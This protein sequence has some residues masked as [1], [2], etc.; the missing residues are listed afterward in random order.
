MSPADSAHG[1]GLGSLHIDAASDRPPYEQVRVGII[2]LIADGTLLVGERLP[3]V[4]A[5][6]T[7][8]GVAANTVARS[9]RELEAAG[10]IETRGRMGSFIKA[11]RNDALDAGFAAATT[12][13]ETARELG[14]D[15]QVIV[16]MVTRAL[17]RT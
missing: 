4:R 9:Y 16:E 14:L 10:V 2:D 3:T 12:F 7:Q 6:A 11:G 15:D 13:V 1:A 17:G 8:L 5:L